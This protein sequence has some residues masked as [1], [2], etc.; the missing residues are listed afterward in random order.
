MSAV[1]H[2]QG[3]DLS[4]GGGGRWRNAFTYSIDY[5]MLDAEAPPRV[6]AVAVSGRNRA[7]LNLAAGC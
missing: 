3:I 1:D 2:N 5:V 7:G 6:R 4:T